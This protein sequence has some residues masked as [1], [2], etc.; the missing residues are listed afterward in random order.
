MAKYGF[1]HTVD[2]MT[3]NILRLEFFHIPWIHYEVEGTI[4]FMYKT[5]T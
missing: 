2:F 4:K 5:S 3:L 1:G